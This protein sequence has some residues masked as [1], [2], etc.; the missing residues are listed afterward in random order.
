INHFYLNVIARVNP[1]LFVLSEI[2]WE[3]GGDEIKVDR[4]YISWEISP[5]LQIRLGKF[6]SPFGYEIREY[7]TPVLKLASRPLFVETLEYGEW[8][9]VGVN[10]YGTFG[11]RKYG[12]N[13][14]VAVMNGP[15]GILGD[16][17]LQTTDTNNNKMLAGRVA[18]YWEGLQFGVSYATGKYDPA[19]SLR[20]ALW[21]IDAKWNWGG[22]DIRGEYVARGGDDDPADVVEGAPVAAKPWGYYLQASYQFFLNRPM[23]Y[24]VEPVVRYDGVDPDKKVKDNTDLSRITI[25]VGVMP[26]PH[27]A[28]RAE[29]QVIR[30]KYGPSLDNNG[31]NIIAV[32]D[33]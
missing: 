1:K 25:G 4:A 12:V 21:G 7:Q 31:L 23:L 6:Y 10:V 27:Y 17:D 20:L 14:D 29:Y 8:V 18:A 16:V 19:N 9:D 5:M 33:F 30:E 22:W 3:H 32:A 2:E 26:Y 28:I 24:A 11:V 13:Y 15:K